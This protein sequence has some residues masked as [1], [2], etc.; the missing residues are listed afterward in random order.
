MQYWFWFQL[1]FVLWAM[2]LFPIWFPFVDC[3]PNWRIYKCK[4]EKSLHPLLFWEMYSSF[5]SWMSYQKFNSYIWRALACPKEPPLP[6][7][8]L[9]RPPRVEKSQLHPQGLNARDG[10]LSLLLGP[11]P[12]HYTSTKCCL[13]EVH[14]WNRR[15]DGEDAR[16]GRATQTQDLQD[17]LHQ[18]RAEM[19]CRASMLGVFVFASQPPVL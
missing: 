5:H 1:S 4:L 10:A 2:Q 9:F 16:T 11:Q 3:T 15:G 12:N 8:N 7:N 19:A 18:W 17:M 14:S 6:S 13:Q